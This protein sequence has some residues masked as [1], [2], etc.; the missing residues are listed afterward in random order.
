MQVFAHY[1]R[2]DHF[3]TEGQLLEGAHR[4][5]AVPGR[6]IAGRF[7]ACTPPRGAFELAQSW[8]APLEVVPCAGHRWN[9]PLLGRAVMAAV[10]EVA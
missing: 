2:H 7:D 1:E 4:L 10:A 8:G 3:L 6:V 9:D 5:R